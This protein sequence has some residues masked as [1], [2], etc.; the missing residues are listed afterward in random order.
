MMNNMNFEALRRSQ[1]A[2]AAMNTSLHLQQG[3]D[4]SRLFAESAALMHQAQQLRNNLTFTTQDAAQRS[5]ME[6]LARHS[7]TT[8]GD[9]DDVDGD[10]KRRVYNVAE[11]N[12]KGPSK[13]AR[14]TSIAGLLIPDGDD[15]D[16]AVSIPASTEG[17]AYFHDNDV[18]SGRGGG[19]NVHP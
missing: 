5:V 11:G 2:Q 10:T 6:V 3:A 13:K 19:T 4:D 15:K 9:D 8:E 14:T 1:Q 12:A 16:D 7:T 17:L 18:L